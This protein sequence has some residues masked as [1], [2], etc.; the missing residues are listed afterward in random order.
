MSLNLDERQRAMLREM[1]IRVW[2]PEFPAGSADDVLEK[3]R[4]IQTCFM[5]R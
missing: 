3:L 5:P 1:G 4:K 2:Q